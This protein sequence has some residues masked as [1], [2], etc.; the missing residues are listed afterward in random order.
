MY[1]RRMIM[2]EECMFYWDIM[3]KPVTF[4]QENW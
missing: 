2:I 1:V 4:Q 3:A